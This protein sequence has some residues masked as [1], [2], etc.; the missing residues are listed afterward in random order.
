MA[1]LAFAFSG[2]ADADTLIVNAVDALLS[3]DPHE[4]RVVTSVMP[5]ASA[6]ASARASAAWRRMALACCERLV[7]SQQWCPR[8][9]GF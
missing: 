2:D 6:Q 5:A 3:A 1:T 4:V 9:I 7:M 8:R